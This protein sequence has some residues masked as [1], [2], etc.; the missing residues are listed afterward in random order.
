MASEDAFTSEE[1]GPAANEFRIQ[2]AK[3]IVDKI[4]PT[5]QYP[6]VLEAV[7]R[8]VLVARVTGY[9]DSIE[10][11]EGEPVKK[12]DLLF[13]IDPRPYQ[14][15]FK[16]AEAALAMARADADLAQ[17]ESELAQRLVQRKAIP[18][19]DAD[20]R[21]AQAVIALARVQEAEARLNTAPD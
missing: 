21:T 10:F 11:V 14:A 17:T 5:E 7:D 15:E 1:I 4:A 18:V 19:E 3:P 2:V 8:V 20:R 16:A 9:L 12:G 13:R 6:A